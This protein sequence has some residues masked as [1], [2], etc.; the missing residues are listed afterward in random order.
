MGERDPDFEDPAGEARRIAK[1]LSAEVFLVP[2]A[3]HYSPAECPELVN[4]RL[5]A[6]ANSCSG[7]A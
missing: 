5:S 2:G 1:Q 4:P 3:G 6:F 7:R